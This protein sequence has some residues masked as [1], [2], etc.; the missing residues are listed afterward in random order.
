MAAS[1]ED[2]ARMNRSGSSG[3]PE[4]RIAADDTLTQRL[5]LRVDELMALQRTTQELNATL[6]LDRIL[7]VVL[8]SAVH[9]SGATH[10][11]VLLMDRETGKYLLR[12]A[13]GYTSADEAVIR[14][15]ATHLSSDGLA[16]GATESGRARIVHDVE[17]DPCST[18]ARP[19]AHSALVVPIFYQGAVAGVIQVYH[20]RVKA[21]EE[22]DL[23]FVEALAGQA[24]VA[25][26]NA[27][28]FEEQVQ[29]NTA[30]RRRAEQMDSLL[31]VGQKLRAD[32]ALEETLEEVAYAIQET[33]GFNYVIIN[34]V[35]GTP[36]RLVR[37]AAAGVP[38]D[39]WDAMQKV[40]QPVE[41]CEC[42][43]RDEYRQEL[44]Y[45]FP[46][47]RR[48]DW[49]PGLDTYNPMTEVENWQEGAW[50]PDDMLLA[51][52][53]GSG[54]RLLGYI[55]VDGP[56]DDKRP[57]RQTLEVLAIF[58]NQAAIAIQNAALFQEGQRRIAEL[59]VLNEMSRAIGSALD[60]DDLLAIVHEQVSRIFDT[61]NFYVAAYQEGDDQWSLA[62]ALERGQ[63]APQ[64]RYPVTSGLIGHIIRSRQPVLL[65][66]LEE[67]VAFHQEQAI[68]CLGE[69]ARS[70]MGVPLMAADQV[71][72]VMAIHSYDQEG[73]YGDAQLAI[74]SAIAAQVAVAARNARLYRQI[75]NMTEELE[76]RVG[77]R[78]RDL[79]LALNELTAERDRAEAL[80][81]ITSELGATL[82]LERVLD[83][84]LKLFAD[85]LGV[86]HGTITL[87]DQESGYLHL[88]AALGPDHERARRHERSPLRRGVGLA[89]WTLEHRRPVLVPDVEQDPRWLEIEG[90][91]LQV[92]SVVAAPLSLGGGDILG[93]LTLGH[94]TVGYFN[95]DHLQLVTAAA[96][97]IAI[98]VNNSDLYA[99]ITE[100]ADQLGSMLQAQQ[101][102]SAKS[103]AILE[104]IA[105]GVLVL[106]HNGRVLLVNPAA[107]ELL[108]F[109]AR[110]IEGEHFRHMLGL[111]ETTG[112][113]ELAQLLYTELRA[114]LEGT[115]GTIT[116]LPAKAVRL[117]SGNQALA[118]NIAPLITAVGGAPGL[119][120]ALR[121]I[122]REAQVERLK[123]E[124]IST[125]SH[126]LRTPMTSIK[127]YTDLLFLGMAGGLTDAQRRFLQIIKSNADRLTALVNDILDI[128]RIE[129]GRI[130]LT[131]EPL[132]LGKIISDVILAF[133]EQYRD[134]CLALEWVEPLN[135]PEIRGDTARV[136]QV[137][138]NLLANAWQY[139]PG[140]G[141]VHVTVTP[142][143]G[144]L[145]VDVADTG[146]GI[147]P[148]DIGR[149]F[150]RF[151]RA[152][153]PL[154]EEVGG[155]GLGLSIVKMFVEM[156]GGEIWVESQMGV[157][158]T[159]SFTLPLVTTE[160][161]EVSP[162][163]LTLEA[164]G[165]GTHRH[166]VLVVEDDHDL[167][168]LLRRQLELEGYQVLLAASGRDALWLAK[169]ER[170]QLIT[171]DMMLPDID[172]FSVL[173]QLKRHP[174][175]ASIP[176]IIVSVLSDTER[177]YALGA[178]DYIVKPF[179]QSKLLSSVRRA[180]DPL[181]RT[182]PGTV[183]V[184]DDAADIRAF[185]EQA[186]S[187]HGYRVWTAPG[188]QEALHRV[189]QD[190]PDLI[191]LDLKMPGMD[192]YQVLR[193]LKNEPRTRSIPVIVITASS[194][195]KDRE[196]VRLLGMGASQYLTKPL[197]IQALVTDIKK[198]MTEVQP[199]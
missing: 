65:C 97:Q 9:T 62:F 82:D 154:V 148:D 137:L 130:H 100:Q 24:A 15:A 196:K 162:D 186:L 121:D 185:L 199:E 132:D 61:T 180:L 22:E 90:R 4:N 169:E 119:V 140:G 113:R 152:D 191:L 54:G 68:S 6:E 143:D 111:G 66:S 94:P 146:I 171:L 85:L 49:E 178:V 17:S 73:L 179:D 58:A 5:R 182:L 47:Q 122:S 77:T 14:E 195:D 86:T 174:S 63:R 52:L 8:E 95:Q 35:K 160:L 84:A 128:S 23:S 46:F 1:T 70:W 164:D 189:R 118:V 88:R 38:L 155:T 78:T 36:P 40:S 2:L 187:L 136:T 10:G 71:V 59:S 173:E 106:D 192:G 33:V 161:P 158:S 31:R 3:E 28:R 114:R 177:G 93:V 156:L 117:Q 183:L 34:V 19:D 53:W 147:G 81:R 139:T 91:G 170:P 79:A 198:V 30:L 127:G 142:I 159:F 131:I 25:I 172:G 103:R 165:L 133:Q 193:L 168:L 69:M 87:L 157:G 42:I 105:D 7:Q 57:S 110:V 39:M 116:P 45:F 151:Y 27:W 16:P 194:V 20:S 26:G 74:F 184:V 138:N 167:A 96:S 190:L 181:E 32:V 55:S 125:V 29:A 120:A 89:G 64:A 12:T 175:T 115:E 150:D 104:S 72:G 11:N 92:R 166:K 149:I 141:R 80:Y 67:N 75:V 76:Q 163:L 197:S 129:T 188:G 50:H 144:Y 13:L 43:L 48:E 99:Y 124:F 109:S 102:E 51:P 134:K 21:F 37:V 18:C 56:R 145:Q 60:M 123:N 112:Q 135:L 41:R 83:H 101:A 176:V 107:E 108:G 126:E 153:H 98:A 44:C